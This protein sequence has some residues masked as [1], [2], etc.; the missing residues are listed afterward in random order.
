MD[1]VHKAKTKTMDVAAP[2][3]ARTAASLVIPTRT[4][5]KDGSVNDS[6]ADTAEPATPATA[7]P[8]PHKTIVPVTVSA[9]ETASEQPAEPAKQAPADPKL[10]DSST[11]N[12]KP[13]DPTPPAA[14]ETDDEGS[15]APAVADQ[16]PTPLNDAPAADPSA[17]NTKNAAKADEL[18]KA[19]ER[20]RQLQ[21]YINNRKYFV[22][23]RAAARERSIKRSIF[24]TLVVL[25]LAGV[26]IDLMLDTGIILL[27]QKIPHTH[28]FNLGG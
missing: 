8:Q 21:E 18:S 17:A 4:A 10:A 7:P 14:S 13:N 27:I 23:I 28:F 5:I 22:P 12:A 19:V 6:A 2:K 3:S 11:A 24:L 16:N 1:K 25:I 9:S 15:P 26:L 20:E